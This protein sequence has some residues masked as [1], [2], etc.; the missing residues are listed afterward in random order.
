MSFKKTRWAFLSLWIV[1]LTSHPVLAGDLYSLAGDS[2]FTVLND[3]SPSQIVPVSTWVGDFNGDGIMDL[4][5]DN[6]VNGSYG[7]AETN[8]LFG[9][10][11]KSNRLSLDS[12]F[13]LTP[14][15]SAMGDF[16]NNNIDDFLIVEST[17]IS[18]VFGKVG[19]TGLVDLAQ[20]NA[21]VVLNISQNHNFAYAVVGNFNGDDFT[22]LAITGSF[23]TDEGHILFGP[24]P[25]VKGTYDISAIP[26]QTVIRFSNILLNNLGSGIYSKDVDGDGKDEIFM[27]TDYRVT[28]NEPFAKVFQ[29]FKG[30]SQWADEWD[31]GTTPADITVLGVPN[32][33][34]TI[35]N[36]RTYGIGDFT[37]DGKCEM[38]LHYKRNFPN[39]ERF[40]MLDGSFI[41]LSTP[42]FINIHEGQPGRA[43]PRL[44]CPLRMILHNLSQR[45]TSTG[46]GGKIFS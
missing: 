23:L 8:V 2:D 16:D 5:I 46:T 19:L 24:S 34:L 3:R 35:L 29:I 33:D 45:E 20:T 10:L 1:G 12:D 11:N 27:S 17:R 7:N 26:H 41:N 42:A 28:T 6:S 15:I 38:F 32:S 30:R 37:G 9:P 44:F 40:F 36:F 4:A 22:D 39:F 13:R 14:A 18:I 25:F 43:L 21:D 31:M